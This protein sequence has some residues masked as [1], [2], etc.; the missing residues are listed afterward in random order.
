MEA[1]TNISDQETFSISEPGRKFRVG[2]YSPS[3]W[4]MGISKPSMV[5]ELYPVFHRSS[6]TFEV[7]VAGEL[8]ETVDGMDPGYVARKAMAGI[9]AELETEGELPNGA[10]RGDGSWILE[11]TGGYVRPSYEYRAVV[12]FV[13][14]KPGEI[15]ALWVASADSVNRKAAS[16]DEPIGHRYKV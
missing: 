16:V 10:R 9:R 12:W 7:C 6:V 3:D 2:I 8:P 14:D 1:R 13:S 11:Q 4:A 5:V 15:S